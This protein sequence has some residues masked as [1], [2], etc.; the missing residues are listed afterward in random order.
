MTHEE[1]F[2]SYFTSGK[3]KKSGEFEEKKRRIAKE[4]HSL[5][6]ESRGQKNVG[7]I[8]YL[9]NQ[10]G[11]EMGILNCYLRKPDSQVLSHIINNS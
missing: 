1:L 9:S 5:L 2:A 10:I 7:N 6:P 8:I 4:N 11:E 3:T